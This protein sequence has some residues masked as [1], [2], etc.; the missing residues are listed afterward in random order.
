MCVLQAH[1]KSYHSCCFRCVICKQ[2][3]E[4]QPFTVDSDSRVYC[5]SDYHKIRAPCCAVCRTPNTGSTE[6]IRVVSS[7]RNYHVECYSGEVNLV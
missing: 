6:S 7:N 4:G 3:L 1:G 2:G 5:V